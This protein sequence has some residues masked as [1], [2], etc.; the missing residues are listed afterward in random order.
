MMRRRELAFVRNVLLA[1]TICLALGT[2]VP[3]PS[4]AAAGALRPASQAS[5]MTV[6]IN[7]IDLSD[8]PKLKLYVTVTSRDGR[9][10]QGLTAA[11][12]QA[13]EDGQLKSLSD[14]TIVSAAPQPDPVRMVLALDTSGSVT[15]SLDKIKEAAIAFVSGLS[16][17]DKIALLSF[18]DNVTDVQTFTNNTDVIKDRIRGLQAGGHTALFE[19]IHHAA[20]MVASQTGRRAVVILTDGWNDT[21]LKRT[22]QE[23]TDQAVAANA[24]TFVMGFGSQL[25]KHKQT[26]IDIATATGGRYF[27][28]PSSDTIK[29]LFSQLTGILSSQYILTYDTSLVA[30][31]KSHDFRVEVARDG[32]R[33]DNTKSLLITPAIM[34]ILVATARPTTVATPP[35]MVPVAGCLQSD[36]QGVCTC[37]DA[38]GDGK[39]DGTNPLIW[40]LGVVFAALVLGWLF[41]ARRQG[42]A[43]PMG[44]GWD[45]EGAGTVAVGM[46]QD[47]ATQLPGAMAMGG[48][49]PSSS[50]TVVARSPIA[51]T[52]WLI[53]LDGEV[54][55]RRYA[56]NAAEQGTTTFGRSTDNTHV[57]DGGG[58]VSRQH[59]HVRAEHGQFVIRDMGARNPVKV[60]GQ[61]I[62]RHVL[63]DGDQIEL[64]NL[65]FIF[66]R[67]QAGR[68]G[69]GDQ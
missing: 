8:Y 6:A 33:A 9:P 11:A 4:V 27:E 69:R 65:R 5:G 53:G 63:A 28:T 51:V 26:A 50:A 19:V 3:A 32:D 34:P 40:L 55:N 45:D 29:D 17:R 22:Q 43:A 2:G 49:P 67:G 7:Q 16:P 60:N 30:D 58:T 25:E 57:L 47:G 18:S 64:G 21:T 23:A 14:V 35:A 41:M 56:L 59:A 44:S 54:L 24:P 39:C 10:V 48:G 20:G 61:A 36:A 13:Q 38:N 46:A 68:S 37:M 12:F 62:T 66:K 15:R 1:V 31:S 42:A 52:A